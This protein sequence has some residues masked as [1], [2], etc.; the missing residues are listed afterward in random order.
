MLRMGAMLALVEK[1]SES[2]CL[3]AKITVE[4]AIDDHSTQ[5]L[6]KLLLLAGDD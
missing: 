4:V 1:R 6:M 3:N 5:E 2:R